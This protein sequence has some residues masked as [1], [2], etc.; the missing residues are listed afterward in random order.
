MNEF[1]GVVLFR[2]LAIS[3]I[4]TMKVDCPL[5]KGV[6][7]RDS[8]FMPFSQVQLPICHVGVNKRGVPKFCRVL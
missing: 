5:K 1:F 3:D 8:F 2:M 7:M 6:A 4:S